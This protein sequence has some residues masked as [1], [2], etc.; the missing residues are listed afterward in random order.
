LSVSDQ[1]SLLTK[2]FYDSN[3]RIYF[4]TARNKRLNAKKALTILKLNEME[5]RRE[6]GEEEILI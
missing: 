2:Q 1:Q 4:L 3:S 6:E 5:R